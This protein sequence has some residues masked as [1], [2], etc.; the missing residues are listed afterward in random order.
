MIGKVRQLCGVAT[1]VG[2]LF[3]I[4]LGL[5][6]DAGAVK[7][8]GLLKIGFGM[9]AVKLDPHSASGSGD[10]YIMAQIYERL[11]YFKMNEATKTPEA[12]PCLAER[13]E[14]SA[15]KT[16]WTFYL[17]KGVTFTDGTPFNAE[18]VK[19]NIDRLLG[20]PPQSNAGHYAP[21][22]KNTEV[23]DEL[24]VRV[25]LKVPAV[26]VE[27]FFV[28]SYIGMVSPAAVQKF[29]DKIG[30]N[31]VG[32]GPYKLKEWVQG[33]KV[34]LEANL[35]HWKG[36]PNLDTIEFRFVP[37]SATRMNMLNTGQVDLVFNLDIPDLEQ[38]KEQGKFDVIEWP[39]TELLYLTL[40]NLAKPTNEM[41]VRQAIKFAI[42]R[43]GIVDKILRGHGAAATS[44]IAPICFGS[45]PV[46]SLAFDPEKAKKILADAGWAENKTT[47]TRERGGEKL[48]LKIRYP[49]GRYPMCD[50]MVA[51]IQNQLKAIGIECVTEKMG[52]GAWITALVQP[53]E[54]STGDAFIVSWPS[55]EDAQWALRAMYSDNVLS[56]YQNKEVQGLIAKQ[57]QEWD[58]DKRMEILKEIQ[59]IAN[60]EAFGVNVYFMNYNIVK[61]K[62]VQGVGPVQVPV[63]DTFNV[64]GAWIE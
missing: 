7:T 36:R 46:D 16:A 57:F 48:T 55:K 25:N 30:V 62:N 11:L 37:E 35:N 40:N 54:K 39:T 64:L 1:G 15:D 34:V 18:A 44:Y 43:K 27:S 41:A 38:I 59:T 31:P 3:L 33:E 32:T 17:R 8:G 42:D 53:P 12:I 6:F 63:S 50:E 10:V 19:F 22:I 23:I 5:P 52:F 4:L 14:I 28:Q 58:K 51:V 24:T 20:P 45:F 49:S 47:G 26:P 13:W 61:K 2:S 9:S 56:F 21:L 60:R 29:G